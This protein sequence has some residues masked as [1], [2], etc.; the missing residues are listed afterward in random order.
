MNEAPV[1]RVL[2]GFKAFDPHELLCHF[3]AAEGGLY[4]RHGI[5]VR[6]V[7]ITFVPDAE[8]PAELFQVS[9][10]AALAGALQGNGQ[11]VVFVATDRPML[12]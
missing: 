4:S 12:T 5:R 9:C 11:R 8:L 2:L 10:G 7:D 6:L 3:V 1:T